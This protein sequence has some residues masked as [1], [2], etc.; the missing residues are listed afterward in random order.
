[1]LRTSALAL[2]M[3]SA[4]AHAED[5][6]TV[7]GSSRVRYESIEGQ[8]RTGF[9]PSDDLLSLRSTLAID[10]RDGPLHLGA[11][12]WDSRAYAGNAGTPITTNEVN[13][14]E[15]VQAYLAYD[16]A[17]AFGKGTKLALQAGRFTLN[18]GSRRLVAAD[19][20]RN[21]TNGYTG[22]RADAALPGKVTATLFYTLPQ[23]RLPGA[24]AGVVG[25]HVRLDR[26]SFDL[27]LWGGLLSKRLGDG[28]TT[29]EATY[30]RLDERDRPDLATR[31]RVLSTFG[32]RAYRDP[33]AGQPDFE[34][35]AF[36]Q[37]GSIS[38]S[39]APAAAKLEVAAWFG[40]A[41]LGY[42]WQHPWAPHV[43]LEIDYASGDGR[44]PKYGRFDT[45]FGMRRADIAPSGLYN[46]VGRANLIAAG[47]RAEITPS[48]RLDVF[49]AYRP[50]WL[51]S[52]SDSFSTTGTRD[53]SGASGRFAGHQLDARVRYWLVPKRLR[54]EWDGVFLAKGRFLTDAPNANTRRDTFYNSFNATVSL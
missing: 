31:D 22:L 21:T 4:A 35:E 12:I 30:I 29:L 51:A 36:A 11:E 17:H 2:L 44:G 24:R 25:N 41:E 18:L 52:A 14:L 19:D 7:G 42:T 23:V 50:L 45:L 5:G 16:I 33:K 20:Y 13:A 15:P 28:R 27:V 38:A 54:L 6:L 34:V 48:K 1:M 37:T 26:E 46:A 10:Y 8:P 49:A 3:A 43:S 47:V 39:L 40:H 9:N 53:A 32:G